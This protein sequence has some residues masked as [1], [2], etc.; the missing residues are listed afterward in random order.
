MY[1][2]ETTLFVIQPLCF[3]HLTVYC[4][5]NAFVPVTEKETL[6]NHKHEYFLASVAESYKLLV[7]A[8]QWL[9]RRLSNDIR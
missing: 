4:Y 1:Y 2:S 5:F 3:H 6:M 8:L 7:Y 9:F